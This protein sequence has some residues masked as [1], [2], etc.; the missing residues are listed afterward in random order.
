MKKLDLTV[1]FVGDLSSIKSLVNVH[2]LE[3]LYLT[4]NPC[5][6]YPGYREFVIAT[7][8]QLKS[9]DGIEITK[10]ERIMALQNLQHICPVIDEKQREHEIKRVGA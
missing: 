3:E 2:F 4:G 10:S 1:N 9:L 8:P 5:T 6:E 7:L